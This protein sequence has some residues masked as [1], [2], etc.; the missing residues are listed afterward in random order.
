M[1]VRVQVSTSQVRMNGTLWVQSCKL[2]RNNKKKMIR[3]G[4][5]LTGLKRTEVKT[6]QPRYFEYLKGKAI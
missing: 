6:E 3:D 1:V 4:R 5:T 2:I